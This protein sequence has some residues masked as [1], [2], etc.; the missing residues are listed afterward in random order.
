[1]TIVWLILGLMTLTVGAEV[2]VRG[3]SS[4]ARAVG[5]PSL[6]IGLTVVA[7]GTSAPE[8]AVSIKAGWMEQGDI[9]LGNVVGSNTFNVLFIL[10]ISA[11]IAPLMASRQLIRLDVPIMI[12][13]SALAW[14]L[15]SNG[16]ISR[17]EGLLLFAG[18]VGYTV[19]LI[20]LGRRQTRQTS[21]A[22]QDADESS[23]PKQSNLMLS[24][25]LVVAGLVLL[26]LGARWFVDGAVSLAQAWGV[27]DLLIGLT[28]VAAGTSM[29]EVATS[30]VASIRGQRDIAIG[31]VVGS[32]IFNLLGVLGAASLM[33]PDGVAVST[34]ILRF[35][36]PVMIAAA[37]ICLPIFFTGGRISRWEG[38]V[39]LG[40]Y[41]A[42][43]F[44]LVLAA[45]QHEAME[46]FGSAMLWF[47]IPMTVIGIGVSLLVALRRRV[48]IDHE[49]ING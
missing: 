16:S 37:L 4:L 24:S 11:L 47:V 9:A 12:G 19:W 42:Y 45:T 3:A 25:L 10:G 40:Y 30:I 49:P 36:L 28:I 39:L 29:P 33:S 26:V 7:Y 21:A 15:A 34:P 8:F 43:V 23:E 5:L 32:N 14:G 1:M 6:I 35:D 17:G 41:I 31:N 38:G 2:M 27:S 46:P 22:T 20:L 48:T 13:V 18:M 44:F